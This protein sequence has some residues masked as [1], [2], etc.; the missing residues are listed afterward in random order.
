VSFRAADLDRRVANTVQLGRI[1]SI[2]TET[3]RVRVALGDI[4]TH[5]I[6][7]AQLASGAI[8]FHWMPSPG[9]QVVVFAPGGDL[10]RAFV[11]GSVPQADGPVAPDAQTPTID[12]G[13]GTL[14]IVGNLAVDGD[15][16][17]TGDVT[18]SGVSLV[19]HTHGGV[20]PGGGNT[21][22]PNA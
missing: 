1:V 8:R 4:E 11:Q 16:T 21:G 19:T 2:A 20:T 3:M 22:G 14:N 13:G 9:E 10:A 12:L 6:P 7:V 15:I 18:A 17:A 5:P